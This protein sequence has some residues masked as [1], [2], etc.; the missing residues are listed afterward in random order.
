MD[1]VGVH[2]LLF[3]LPCIGQKIK[4][5]LNRYPV[6][7]SMKLPGVRCKIR[8]SWLSPVLKRVLSHCRLSS[9]FVRIELGRRYWQA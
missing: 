2:A 3:L 6:G 1:V 7:L 4:P 9:L 8:S 5:S